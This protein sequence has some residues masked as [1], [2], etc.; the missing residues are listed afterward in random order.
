MKNIKVIGEER[1]TQS[2][3]TLHPKAIQFLKE[4]RFVYFLGYGFDVINNA[5]LFKELHASWLSGKEIYTTCKG[6]TVSEVRRTQSEAPFINFK[7]DRT[8]NLLE[9]DCLKLLKE[10]AP[11]DLN[12]PPVQSHPVQVHPTPPT[13]P[14]SWMG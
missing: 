8:G 13:G 12:I 5:F 3:S 6:L 10:I 7:L 4:S 2:L 14:H 11:I 1:K 9:I